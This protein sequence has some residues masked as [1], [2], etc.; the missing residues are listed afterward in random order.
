MDRPGPNARSV[1][2]D[3]ALRDRSLFRRLGFSIE[4]GCCRKRPL[5]RSVSLGMV[6]SISQRFT[7][8]PE[9]FSVDV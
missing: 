7:R 5:F 4:T 9:D 6:K 1:P 8:N 2:L 3:L